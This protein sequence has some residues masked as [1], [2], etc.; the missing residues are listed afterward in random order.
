MKS[1]HQPPGTMT[2]SKGSF[3]ASRAASVLVQGGQTVGLEYVPFPR[4]LAEIHRGKLTGVLILKRGRNQECRVLFAKGAPV[5]VESSHPDDA[6]EN[7][8]VRKGM[9]DQV[10]AHRSRSQ[11]VSSG[12]SI[13]EVLVEQGYVDPNELY[14]LI[15]LNMGQ[16]L[17]SLFKWKDGKLRFQARALGDDAA[18]R[19]EVSP[20]SLIVRGVF[21]YT[22][23]EVINQHFMSFTNDTF[24]L[25]EDAEASLPALKLTSMQARIARAMKRPIRTGELVAEAEGDMEALLRLLY[26]LVLLGVAVPHEEASRPRVDLNKLES[27]DRP[28]PMAWEEEVTGPHPMPKGY[29]Q[30]EKKVPTRELEA[31]DE[32]LATARAD[33]HY[34]LLRVKPDASFG[35]IRRA[36]L[37]LCHKLSP[38]ALRGRV[39]PEREVQAE[40]VF[41][42]LVRAYATLARAD[43]RREYNADIGLEA[44]ARKK[45][46]KKP[47]PRR[48]VA[49]FGPWKT[50]IPRPTLPTPKRTQGPPPEETR[51]FQVVEPYQP[52]MMVKTALLLVKAGETPEAIQELRKSLSREKADVQGRA[53]LGYLLYLDDPVCNMSD[54]TAH[55]Q[56]AAALDTSAIEPHLYMGRIY[57]YAQHYAQALAAYKQVLARESRST[58][59]REAVKR[60]T[61]LAKGR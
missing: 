14:K 26:A 37:G 24:K 18:I 34:D 50:P 10:I 47:V 28:L 3:A 19:L 29:S 39:P 45:P 31:L 44:P 56:R 36:F 48:G 21:A 5:K 9:L 40:E 13:G 55:L 35:E 42:L 60:L 22:P 51:G 11:A 23:F 32:A 12:H 6:L 30:D 27:V 57:E 16:V 38:M 61:K 59:A 1:G 2:A 15:K 43:L 54:A 58:E 33:S 20:E 25:A 8:L 7:M 17:L 49:P 46:T 52:T 4:A 41:L 53:L